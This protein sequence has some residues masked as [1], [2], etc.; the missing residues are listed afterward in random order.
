MNYILEN[1]APY[2]AKSDPKRIGLLA[3][4]M[5]LVIGMTGCSL[6]ME[7]LVMNENAASAAEEAKAGSPS[8]DQLKIGRSEMDDWQTETPKEGLTGFY[9]EQLS[10]SLRNTY[11]QLYEGLFAYKS[12]FYVDCEHTSD[13]EKAFCALLDDHP[14]C[15]WSDGEASL[16]GGVDGGKQRVTP[17]YNVPTDQIDGIKAAIEA[18]ADDYLASL[19]ADATSY[20]KV[21]AAYR[22]IIENTDYDLNSSQSQNIQSVFLQKKSVC[23]GYAK[24][25]QYLLKMAGVPCRYVHGTIASSNE[26]HAWNLVTIDGVN[27]WVD[28]T[29]GDPTYGENES[30]SARLSIIYDYLCMTSEELSRTGHILDAS[31]S[32]PTCTDTTYDFYGLLNDYMTTYDPEEVQSHFFATVDAQEGVTYLKFASDEAYRA[33]VEDIFREDGILQEPLQKQMRINGLSSI[34]YFYSNSDELRTIKIFW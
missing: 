15:F 20:Q 9:Y 22:F 8:F 31:Y 5:S 7:P 28:P 21:R 24:A 10:E 6:P 13:I 19:P 26:A 1:I 32:Y 27:T 18:S 14:E 2:I 12:E 25:F 16:Y 3:G 30:D 34:Q 29:W 23:A 4:V 33:A 17:K 11:S